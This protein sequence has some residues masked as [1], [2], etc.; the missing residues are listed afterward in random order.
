MR[1][2]AAST[3]RRD[4]VTPEGVALNLT[5]ADGGSRVAAFVIDLL[6]MLAIVIGMTVLAALAGFSLQSQYEVI[7]TIWV[8]GFFLLRNGYFIFM[9][10]GPRG[11]TFGKRRMGLRVCARGGE[12]LTADAV[13]ARNL[14]RE[15]EVFL[16]LTFILMKSSTEQM[17][18]LLALLGMG[19]TGM[20]LAFPLLNRDRL[21]VG[22]MLAGTWVIAVPKRELLPDMS[23]AHT[24][25][26]RFTDRQLAVYGVYELQILEGLLRAEDPDGLAVAAA[27]IRQKI[28]ETG[29]A[30][31]RENDRVFLD[32]YY[33]ALR[34]RLE[35][36]LLF[37]KRKADK[38]AEPVARLR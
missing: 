33:T 4:L 35:Q 20:L 23:T 11:A 27:S 37:G 3:L 30:G 17:D 32:S 29:R 31:R 28:G 9:E 10:L 15:I 22:D 34:Q 6:L 2:E 8:L 38:H 36:D 26:P 21:R 16:P 19:W 25:A 13:I 24:E 7:G 5:L 18:G 1:A 14:I 12:R